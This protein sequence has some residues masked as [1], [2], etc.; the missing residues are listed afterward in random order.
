M[1]RV[2][3]L[4]VSSDVRESARDRIERVLGML[5]EAL[6]QADFAVL[7]EL[8]IPGAFDLP[9]AREVAAPLDSSVLQRIRSMAATAGAWVHAGTYAERLPDGRTFNTAALIGPAGEIVATY[10]K[11]HL[12]GFETGERTLMSAGDALVVAETPLGHTGL[13]TCYDLRFP[14]MFR[15]LVDT[16]A[17]T[18][19]LASGWP[20]PRIE[21]WRVLARARAIENLAWV[22]ACNGVGSHADITLGGHSIVVDPQGNVIAEAGD[23]EEVLFADVEPGRSQEWREAFP[24][25]GDR[26]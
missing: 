11:R 24:A 26:R 15:A 4:Q 5:G 1:S 14:E 17:T 6:T 21:H 18:F 16:G 13:A 8:W 12:F 10:R 23:A 22:V 20:V 19:L 9:L 2:A 3:L 7:P 25:L